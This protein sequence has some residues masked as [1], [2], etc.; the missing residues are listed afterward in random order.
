MQ[1][2]K[3]TVHE[4]VVKPTCKSNQ[5]PSFTNRVKMWLPSGKT[6]GKKL[7]H[8][9]SSVA[10]LLDGKLVIYKIGITACPQ[11]R[12][13]NPDFG[14]THAKW[15]GF[16]RM[17]VIGKGQLQE[18]AMLEAALINYFSTARPEGL[19]NVGPGGEGYASSQESSVDKQFTYVVLKYLN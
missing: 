2:T 18:Q 6:A 12:F 9:I 5:H 17:V 1:V 7:Q 19:Q 3:S 11:F 8:A 16:Q 10:S 4:H 13:E 15:G 14:Y